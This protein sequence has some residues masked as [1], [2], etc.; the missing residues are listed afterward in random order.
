MLELILEGV[1]DSIILLLLYCYSII[2]L[3]YYTCY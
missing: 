3:L 1:Y 2:L